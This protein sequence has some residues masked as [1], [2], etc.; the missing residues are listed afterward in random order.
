MPTRLE[1]RVPPVIL[2]V[3]A[4]LA[5]W[6]T[7]LALPGLSVSQRYRAPLTAVAFMAGLGIT[8]SGVLTFRSARTT[9]SPLD[10]AS[11]QLLVTTGV[12]RWSHNPM[13]VGFVLSL[14]AWGMWLSTPTS[15]AW[16]VLFA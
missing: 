14:V 15:I 8:L 2:V 16:G 1:L 13:Y 6:L 3:T 11:A 12:Y 10:P 9:V 4:A 5:M 7:D